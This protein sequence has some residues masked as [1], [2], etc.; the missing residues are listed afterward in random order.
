MK[1]LIYT[2]YFYPE[3][4]AAQS[5]RIGD[6]S[7]TLARAGHEVTIVAGFPSHPTGS[8]YPEYKGEWFREEKWEDGT[9]LLRCWSYVRPFNS[10]RA[11]ILNHVSFLAAS[12][13]QGVWATRG[14]RVDV[15]LGISPPLFTG[16]AGALAAMLHRT[17]FVLDVQDL[18]PE[19]AVAVGGLRNPYAVRLASGVARFLYK[20]AA[21]NVVISKGFKKAVA[22]QGAREKALH[23]IPNWVREECFEEREAVRLP[24][25]GF[26]VVFAGTIG[27]AQ[28]LEAVVEAAERL[29]ERDV[30]FIFVGE[31]V[32]KERLRLE[33]RRRELENL[34]FLPAVA[35]EDLPAVLAAADA[36]LVHLKPEGI[37][38]VVIPSKTYEYLAA[39]RPIL[40][41]VPGEAARLVEDSGAGVAFPPGDAAALAGAV[42]KMLDLGSEGRR[43]L[44]EAGREYA[45][46]NFAAAKLTARYE[47]ILR[48]VGKP[49][50]GSGQSSASAGD[51]R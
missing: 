45:R 27:L 30:S 15:V 46:E 35:Q 10:S 38:E 26:R 8:V 14:D 5:K 50:R 48:E 31:G 6:L 23:V 41:G 28:G 22:E 4:L 17:P 3:H 12:V 29:R 18:W 24:G 21:R 32:E 49:D 13:L 9:R 19:E 11:R 51:L 44:G 1:V 47:R 36:L 2:H 16:L 33:A 40:M 25:A 43:K 7:R 42:E 34:H 39:G 20:K 37:F